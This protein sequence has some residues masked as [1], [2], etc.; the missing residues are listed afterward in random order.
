MGSGGGAGVDTGS[1]LL[2]YPQIGLEYLLAKQWGVELDVGWLNAPTSR[3]QAKTLNAQINYYFHQKAQAS[4]YHLAARA[5][6]QTYIDPSKENNQSASNINLFSIKFDDYLYDWLY[7]TGQGAFAYSGN[8]AG[9]FSGL[10]G[11]GFE[12]KLKPDSSVSL[13]A[14]ILAGAAGG[15]G[16]D[17]GQGL[18]VAG[19]IGAN[20]QF[21]TEWG[22]YLMAGK[23]FAS[24]GSFSPTTVEA[25]LRY[26]F[27]LYL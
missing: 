23:T 18:I 27:S 12:K 13:L 22:G 7:L 14:E 5:G 16:L 21:T 15:A 10:L 11:V 8:V 9:Y 2:V 17:L 1:G 20:Y 25:G 19:N 26:R 6:N 3:Y 4:P 24:R